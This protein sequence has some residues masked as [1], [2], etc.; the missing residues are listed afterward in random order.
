MKSSTSGIGCKIDITVCGGSPVLILI[1]VL[2]FAQISGY[3][4]ID[5]LFRIRMGKNHRS[6]CGLGLLVLLM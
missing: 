2:S 1:I 5:S 6:L 3:V 4:V